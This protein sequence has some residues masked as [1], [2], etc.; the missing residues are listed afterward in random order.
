M[1]TQHVTMLEQEHLRQLGSVDHNF[2]I[3]ILKRKEVTTELR[4][5]TSNYS[6]VGSTENKQTSFAKTPQDEVQ[7]RT[8]K[9]KKTMS[10]SLFNDDEDDDD[11]E[12][13]AREIQF[14]PQHLAHALPSRESEFSVYEWSSSSAGGID[15]AL[16]LSLQLSSSGGGSDAA[17]D[18]SLKLKNSGT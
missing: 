10:L 5:G 13:F 11:V 15:V 14:F 17:M 1:E 18:H 16:D 8:A 6:I 7:M 2:S 12:T 4:L 9:K 3:K